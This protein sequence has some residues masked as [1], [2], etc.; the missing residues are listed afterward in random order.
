MHPTAGGPDLRARCRRSGERDHL[1]VRVLD[2]RLP[3]LATEPVNQLEH[4]GRQSRLEQQ[5]DQELRGVG[6]VLRGLPDDRVST[7]Q[8]REDLPRRDGEREVEWRDDARH[9]NR[10]AVA[11]RPLA[12]ELRGDGAAEQTP[13]LGV[14]V[15][16]GVDPLLHV[17][18]RLEQDLAHLPRHGPGQPLLVPHQE[19]ADPLK[20]LP[21]QR[22]GSPGPLSEAALRR[23]GCAAHVFGTRPWEPP[24]DVV[25]IRGVAVLEIRAG[26]GLDPGAGD[27]I[28]ERL[29]HQ[30]SAISA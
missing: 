14:R 21:A 2:Q 26:R 8:R 27:E 25:P 16:G 1:H 7:E 23:R 19:I 17:A 29:S 13:P 18:P 10:P 12:P 5:L 3:R 28:L 4:L 24:D 20:H 22:R 6:H 9:P 30:P 11:H 15:V